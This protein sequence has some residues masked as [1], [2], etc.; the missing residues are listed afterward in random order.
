MLTIPLPRLSTLALRLP[1]ALAAAVAVV[2]LNAP[3]LAQDNAPAAEPPPRLSV[4]VDAGV[5]LPLGT[6]GRADAE[7]VVGQRPDPARVHGIRHAFGHFGEMNTKLD[8]AAAAFAQPGPRVALQLGYRLTDR[9]GLRLEAAASRHRSDFAP[10]EDLYEG[11]GFTNATS[12]TVT[13][14]DYRSAIVTAGAAY[15]LVAAGALRVEVGARAGV[16]V[17]AYPG[18]EMVQESPRDNGPPIYYRWGNQSEHYGEIDESA[19]A[20][21]ALATELRATRALG[22]WGLSAAVTHAYA[23]YGYDMRA[24]SAGHDPDPVARDEIRYNVV[25]LSLGLSY[26]F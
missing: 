25:G 19:V 7:A 24:R 17:L 4:G 14:D 21:L 18:L 23:A 5:G 8:R 16:G 15:A 1:T 12:I 6:F 2:G 11:I 26:G 22:A 3:A 13:G 10:L 9:L 20:G